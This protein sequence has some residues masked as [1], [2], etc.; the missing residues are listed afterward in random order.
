MLKINNL[1]QEIILV[2]LKYWKK[3]KNS[4]SIIFY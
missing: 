3:N 2:I 1:I 4:S